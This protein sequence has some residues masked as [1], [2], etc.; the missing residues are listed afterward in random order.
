[1]GRE[2]RMVHKDWVHPLKEGTANHKP[3]HE[4]YLETKDEFEAMQKDKGLQEAIDYFGSA[5]DKED[6]V[7]DWSDEEKTHYMLYETVLEGTPLSPAIE[8][9]EKLA[10]WLVDNKGDA[11]CGQEASY[12]GW[13]RV[14]NG[15]YAP[16]MIFSNGV[17]NNGVDGL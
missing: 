15:G 8:T 7:P 5:P 4:G 2:V 14:C 11:G 17:M 9:P 16:S 3:L 10:Q 13:L 6:Y 12:E 1:M